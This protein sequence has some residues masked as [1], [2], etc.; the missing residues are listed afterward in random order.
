M[1]SIRSSSTTTATN[2]RLRRRPNLRR[3]LVAVLLAL[4]LPLLA[5]APASASRGID[6]T[7]W[8]RWYYNSP[9]FNAMTVA[10]NVYG[11]RC[12]YGSDTGT[13]LNVDMN[14]ACAHQYGG[15]GDA[16][17]TN[18]YDKYSWYCA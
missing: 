17:F 16:R 4:P 9:A 6:I 11:W 12:Q 7:S 13:R 2:C 18:Y 3:L 14:S 10:N 8:C 15:R 5:A 1:Q